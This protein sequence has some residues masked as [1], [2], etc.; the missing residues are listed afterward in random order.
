MVIDGFG[1][2]VIWPGTSDGRMLCQNNV[3]EQKHAY[4]CRAMAAFWDVKKRNALVEMSY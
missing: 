1:G 2:K 3:N 4:I